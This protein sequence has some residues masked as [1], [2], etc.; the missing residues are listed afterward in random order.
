MTSDRARI[1]APPPLIGIVCIGLAYAAEH[2]KPLPIFP[3]KNTPQIV[4]G[5]A[6]IVI[7]I[8]S[9]V[10]AAR[11]FIAHGTHPSPYR[12][13]TAIV[14]TGIYRLSRNPIY[15]AFL[16]VVLAIGLLANSYWFLGFAVFLALVLHFG[17]IKREETYLL[18]KFGDSYRQYCRQV[19]RWI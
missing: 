19:R 14:T 8:G 6:L 4:V 9:A 2:Y 16:L 17:V 7:A 15:I 3:T 18:G 11:S 10:S 13:T 5:I 1:I 12:P